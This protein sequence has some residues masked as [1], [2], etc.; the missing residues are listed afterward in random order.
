MLLNCKLILKNNDYNSNQKEF[1]I[2]NGIWRNYNLYKLY[3]EA[4][5]PWS[6]MIKSLN[7]V[8]S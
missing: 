3:A 2:K 6:G 5:T 1:V 7:I 4:K 8:K